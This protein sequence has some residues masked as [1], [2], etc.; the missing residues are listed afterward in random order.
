M[1]ISTPQMSKYHQFKEENINA[2]CNNI[3]LEIVTAWKLLGILLG[4]SFHL[5][6]NI[7][8]LF[9][10]CYLSLSMQKKLNRYPALPLQKQLTT[11]RIGD[12]L[13]TGL[14]Q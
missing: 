1:V 3:T 7:S 6:K 8:K 5:D 13:Q 12:I 2:K 11:D 9:K 10:D 14:L 4:E